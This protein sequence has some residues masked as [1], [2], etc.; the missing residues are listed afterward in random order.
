M[1]SITFCSWGMHGFTSGPALTTFAVFEV[2]PLVGC[3]HSCG[4]H[5]YICMLFCQKK[6]E[7]V[8]VNRGLSI[9]RLTFWPT[10]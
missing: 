9:W 10:I 6:K 7:A 5:I 8:T 1:Q 2:D 3:L 4:L